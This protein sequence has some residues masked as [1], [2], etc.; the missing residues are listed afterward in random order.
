[1]MRVTVFHSPTTTTTTTELFLYLK[2]SL[3]LVFERS[4]SLYLSVVE[5]L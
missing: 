2:A 1:M 5:I 3:L 4:G